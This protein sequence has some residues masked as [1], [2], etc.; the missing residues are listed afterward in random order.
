MAFIIGFV[1]IIFLISISII[2]NIKAGRRIIDLLDINAVNKLQKFNYTSLE[3][4]RRRRPTNFRTG[5]SA[6][7]Q[8][9]ALEFDYPVPL[10]TMI[11]DVIEVY[12][13]ENKNKYLIYKTNWSIEYVK[14]LKK[15]VNEYKV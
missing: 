15:I 5:S 11:D 9:A 3:I 1:V 8:D 7:Y 10:I 4:K 2:V 6:P 12:G 13:I 14:S